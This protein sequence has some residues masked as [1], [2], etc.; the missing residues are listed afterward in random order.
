MG[1]NVN[2]VRRDFPI[3]QKNIV[4]FDNSCVTLRPE[5]VIEAMNK[6]YREF[7]ACAGR[8]MHQ[9]GNKVTE[10][11]DKARSSIKKFINAKLKA[12]II[13]TRNTTES[14]NLIA[15]SF[16]FEKGDKVMITDKEHNSNLLP[17]QFLA[18]KGIIR[19]KIL[20]S[21]EDNTFNLESFEREV[22][23]V[24]LVSMVHTSNMDG[25][26]NPVKD[27][28]KIAH[29]NGALVMLDA[30]Q[31]APHHEIDVRNLDVDFLAFSG[32]KMLGPS[33][34]GVLYGKKELL[35]NLNP[36]LV[37]G[38]TVKDSTYTSRVIEDLP[39][40]FE[41]GL[42]NY[43]GI[44]GLGEAARY[45]MNI[46]INNIEKHELRLTR[47]LTI[48]L[49]KMGDISIIGPG[50]EHRGGI[51]SFN[52]RNKDP[53]QVAMLMD[54][55]ANIMLRSGAHCVH[56]WFNKHKMTGSVRASLYFYNTEEEVDSFLKNLEK[57]K[58]LI[59]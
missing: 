18:E 13:F 3:F 26:T 48:G 35:E 45:L 43:A 7:P 22:K 55:S 31:S 11:V 49:Q 36:F 42:Q 14:I 20:A 24:K 9:L 57:V 53:H 19:L 56:A 50:F 10:E 32:H 28:I 39:H 54:S 58:K 52:I 30:A 33:G 23:D 46:G 41:A 34:I 44:I 47:K 17:W 15:N 6:Y 1:L 8:S 27:I 38:E 59:G 16:K 12:E 5:Q 51:T 29:K 37:G 2:K 21:K 25:V 40:R 4:Y